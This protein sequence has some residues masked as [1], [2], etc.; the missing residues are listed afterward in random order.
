[1][2]TRGGVKSGRPHPES[3]ITDAHRWKELDAHS[4]TKAGGLIDSRGGVGGEEKKKVELACTVH[5]MSAQLEHLTLE[6]LEVFS[7]Q[8]TA[9]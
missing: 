6:D 3:P 2:E 1:M 5:M 8:L 9:L 7:L 4:S